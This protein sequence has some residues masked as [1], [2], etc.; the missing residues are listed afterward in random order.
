MDSFGRPI[1]LDSNL[2]KQQLADAG[3]VDIKEEVIR[4][5]LNARPAETPGRDLGR[6]FNLGIQKACQPLSL[7]PLSRSH[8][9]TLDEICDLSE[10]VRVEMYNNT[11]NAYCTL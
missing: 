5:P 7:A 2:T 1:R 6:W 8:G 11:A 4:L 3:F 9:R 10:K